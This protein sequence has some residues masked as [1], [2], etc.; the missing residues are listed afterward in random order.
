MTCDFSKNF[1]TMPNSE[2]FGLGLK[3][4][5]E[6]PILMLGT[7]LTFAVHEENLYDTHCKI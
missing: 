7:Y 4:A 3:E 1:D 2:F 6:N 5:L